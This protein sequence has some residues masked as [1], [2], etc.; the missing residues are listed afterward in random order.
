MNINP[1]T[2]N[3]AATRISSAT[4]GIPTISTNNSQFSQLLTVSNAGGAGVVSSSGNL[5]SGS[6]ELDAIFE[7][8]GRQYN[9]SPNLLKAVA[10]VESNFRPHAVSGA[11]AQGIMQLMPRTASY[12][13]VTN[14][15]DPQQNIMGGA[16]YLSEQLDR[17]NGDVRLA[18]AA[19]NAGWPAV[20]K[21]G[22]IP[23]FSQTQAYVSKV[24][25]FFGGG[26][27]TAGISSDVGADFSGWASNQTTNRTPNSSAKSL[28]MS[29]L[30]RQMIMM[31]IMNMQMGMGRS[32]NSRRFF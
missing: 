9:I 30:L 27:I 17:F 14:P 31:N 18:L 1:T 13:G 3:N 6:A 23:P 8:A 25:E 16:K 15:F 2:I 24:L 20:K 29:E 12:L 21:H 10:K 5:T 19:Y 22:G 4:H 7:T 11:G 26:D 32:G 28:N